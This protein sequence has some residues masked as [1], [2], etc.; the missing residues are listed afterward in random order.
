MPVISCVFTPS[1]CVLRHGACHEPEQLRDILRQT[2]S[3]RKR[4]K[5]FRQILQKHCGPA[6]K[7]L[8][9]TSLEA[10][11]GPQDVDDAVRWTAYDPRRCDGCSVPVCAFKMLPCVSSKRP[12]HIRHGRFDGTHGSVLNVHTAL[13]S[14]QEHTTHNNTHSPT[15][16]RHTHITHCRCH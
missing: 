15:T 13:I 7:E 8:G 9:L 5:L 1:S 14:V 16:T 6:V 12:C 10:L 4:S 2:L 11:L 3:S